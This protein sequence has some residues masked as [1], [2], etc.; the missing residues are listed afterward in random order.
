VEKG[1]KMERMVKDEYI[2]SKRR[3]LGNLLWN[4]NLAKGEDDRGADEISR[5]MNGMG[6]SAV[7]L[8]WKNENKG[9]SDEDVCLS[10]G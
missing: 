10:S 5:I 8:Y 7:R 3:T 2:V 4:A 9:L 6:L 1:K